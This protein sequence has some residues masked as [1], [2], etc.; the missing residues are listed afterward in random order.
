MRVKN[1][2]GAMPDIDSICSPHQILLEQGSYLAE[3]TNG[4]LDFDIERSQ[5]VAIFRA[6]CKSI[7]NILNVSSRQ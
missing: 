5:K 7:F 6:S 3:T 4:L 1:L 2:W